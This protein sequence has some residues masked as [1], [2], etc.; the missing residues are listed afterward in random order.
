MGGSSGV[1]S[2]MLFLSMMVVGKDD[3]LIYRLGSAIIGSS[4]GEAS[5]PVFGG[6][7]VALFYSGVRL[8][9]LGWHR[10]VIPRPLTYDLA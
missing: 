10:A 1:M 5:L 6:R 8:F 9:R 4:F 7:G 3:P 2:I